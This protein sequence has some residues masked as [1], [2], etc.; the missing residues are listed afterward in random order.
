MITLP[1]IPETER[2]DEETLL[3]KFEAEQ[4]RILGALLDTIVAALQ[5]YPDVN[6][7]TSPR[8][9]D[10]ARFA[11]AAECALGWEEGGFLAAYNRNRV[12]SV[13]AGLDE[14]TI[15]SAIRLLLDQQSPWTGKACELLRKLNTPTEP[16]TS[17]TRAYPKTAPAL[18]KQ[19]KR[20][21]PAL[22]VIG[23]EYTTE[24][25][26]RGGERLMTLRKIPVSPVRAVRNAN[27]DEKPLDFP[28]DSDTALQLNA[29][30][31]REFVSSPVCMPSASCPPDPRET[32]ALVNADS[33]DSRKHELPGTVE[34]ETLETFE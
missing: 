2:R 17:D 14:Y 3:R 34:G 5:R 10:F 4:P 11:T 29:D 27:M 8:M 28:H 12:E 33:A 23:I 18:G 13:E 20:L 1:R 15:V 9:A 24:R 26:G 7:P 21:T 16:R 22:R 31:T 19:L 30:G 32:R 6:L 25:H